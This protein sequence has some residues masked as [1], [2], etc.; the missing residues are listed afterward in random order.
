MSSSCS[1]VI[2][3]LSVRSR[4]Q[5]R[6]ER[7]RPALVRDDDGP[8]RPSQPVLQA[9]LPTLREGGAS[10][11]ATPRTRP[12]GSKTPLGER[13][14]SAAG[15]SE[16]ARLLPPSPSQLRHTRRPRRPTAENAGVSALRLEL[17]VREAAR[18]PTCR[19]PRGWRPT[20]PALRP[21]HRLIHLK[22]PHADVD[23][24]IVVAPDHRA[25]TGPAID[26]RRGLA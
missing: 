4:L 18:F 20:V 6:S 21:L 3:P 23:V 24:V 11:S 14:A 22:A 10:A 7:P 9:D 16:A 15:P 1:S 25:E 17:L 26:T 8:A 19:S 12:S 13:T 5:P 2:I